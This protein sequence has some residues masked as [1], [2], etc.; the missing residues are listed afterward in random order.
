MPDDKVKIPHGRFKGEYPKNTIMGL[1]AAAKKYGLDPNTVLAVALQESNFGK[2]RYDYGVNENPAKENELVYLR[3]RIFSTYDILKNKYNFAPA[4]NKSV[5]ER[6][7]NKI[8]NNKFDSDYDKQLSYEMIDKLHTINNNPQAISL[9]KTLWD[10]EDRINN[11]ENK[12]GKWEKLTNE[13]K[14]ADVLKQKF[15]YAKRLGY[16]DEVNQIQAFNGLGVLQGAIVPQYGIKGDI[17]MRKVP[18]YGNRVKELRENVIKINPQI[19]KMIN[20][21]GSN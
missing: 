7:F 10:Y 2:T 17:D 15:D 18:V 5:Y 8:E 11:V 20:E 1:I 3:D 6:A 21:Y 13:E 4:Y 9:M 19:Q 14:L 16:K 12:Y